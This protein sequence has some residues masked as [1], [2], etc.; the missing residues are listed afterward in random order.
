VGD[1]LGDVR[2]NRTEDLDALSSN[3][4]RYGYPAFEHNYGL[5]Y[6]RRRDAHDVGCR[7]DANAI[8]PFLEQPW[9]RSTQGAACDG[10]PL[11]DLTKFNDWYFQRL[12][13]FAALCDSKGTVLIHK[14]HM[15]HALL[16][17]QAHYA[18]FPWRPQNCLQDTGMPDA[19]PA[20]QAFY[21]MSH[22][23][24]RR[25]QR[26]YIRKCLDELGTYRNVV[27]LPGQEY[28]GPAEFVRFWLDTILEWEADTGA[29]VVAGVGAT[30]DV[31]DALLEDNEYCLHIDAIDLRYWWRRSD[32][33]L[34]A[35]EGGMDVPGR[36][37]ER[38]SQQSG[39]TNARDVYAKIRS[40]RDRWPDKLII[41][42]L[43][44]GTRETWA[45]IMAGGSL[46]IRDGLEYRDKRD[47]LTYQ[48]PM[49]VG[50]FLPS[51][52]FLR[53]HLA[54]ELPDMTPLAISPDGERDRWAL[55]NS[56]NSYLVYA[57]NG[58]RVRL[59]TDRPLGVYAGVWFC[60]LTGDTAP[61][62]PS[63]QPAGHLLDTDAPDERDWM[64]WL[65]RHD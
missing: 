62:Q 46:L 56:G 26:L 59:N 57:L 61:L 18:D 65:K 28:T 5:W 1:P 43:A 39:E 44:A 24:R 6:D 54:S 13:Q 51:Y 22:P 31:L 60:P 40:Y 17:T 38:G 53:K 47:P 2:P 50:K 55:T 23:V 42:A 45:F 63:D 36:G 10:L 64:L 8:P 7:D 4:L 29:D 15:Q 30:K 32:G 34:F 16:E 14:Y 21:D 33:S 37:L 3:M 58:G 9:A 19:I 52:R 20:A 41:D 11:Y 12:K 49:N 25:L 27:H 48:A 35:P